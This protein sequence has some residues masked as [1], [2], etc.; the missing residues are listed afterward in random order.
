MVGN[1]CKYGDCA[2]E[3]EVYGFCSD[4][5]YN[6]YVKEGRREWAK[7]L[8]DALRVQAP[9]L[10]DSS[11]MNRMFQRWGHKSTINRPMLR[12][13]YINEIL[14]KKGRRTLSL[15]PRCESCL[16]MGL[17]ECHCGEEEINR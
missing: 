6:Y 1:L 13:A 8:V 9:D 15:E 10:I 5:F 14:K 3:G 7:K 16:A 17:E 11:E 2:L 4:H 12:V